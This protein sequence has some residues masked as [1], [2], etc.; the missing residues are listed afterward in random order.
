MTAGQ[1]ELLLPIPE[2][3]EAKSRFTL[4]FD[5]GNVYSVGDVQFYDKQLQPIDYH[6]DA[7]NLKRSY[8]ISAQWLAPLGLFRFSYAFPMDADDGTTTL[9]GDKTER[10]QFSIGGAF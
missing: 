1:V 7:S 5:M 4:F 8:G 2:K 9:W 6:F 3:W 10:F